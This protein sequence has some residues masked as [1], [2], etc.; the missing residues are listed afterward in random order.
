MIPVLLKGVIFTNAEHNHFASHLFL[1]FAEKAEI[2]NFFLNP[3]GFGPPKYHLHLLAALQR[4]SAV[5]KYT[6][7]SRPTCRKEVS[8]FLF[9]F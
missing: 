8:S 2:F 7:K 5:F 1:Y 4:L 6:R 3:M 9:F